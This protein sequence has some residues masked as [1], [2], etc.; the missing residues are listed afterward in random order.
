MR[1][2]VNSIFCGGGSR[3]GRGASPFSFGMILVIAAVAWGLSGVYIVDAAE[4]GVVLRLGEFSKITMP[5]IHWYMRSI[6]KVETVDVDN[7]RTVS[8]RA[9]MLTRDE[10]IIQVELAV[11]YRVKDAQDYLF[12]VR[13]P[14]VTLRQAAESA[15][16]E[17]VGTSRLDAILEGTQREAIRIETQ[18]VLQE[19]HAA[20]RRAREP[21][22]QARAA[23]ERARRHLGADGDLPPGRVERLRALWYCLSVRAAGMILDHALG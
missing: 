13:D 11:Q 19:A 17:S 14:E 20:V 23:A 1:D 9:N 3:K 8:H 5:G 16:R 2:G 21:Q 22:E 4:R 15:L 18:R 6:E 7:V 12:Q 10:N